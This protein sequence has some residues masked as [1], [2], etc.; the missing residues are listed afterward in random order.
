MDRSRAQNHAIDVPGVELGFRKL[1]LHVGADQ[2]MIRRGRR[3]TLNC[4][5]IKLV[6][7][8]FRDLLAV[9]GDGP[10]FRMDAIAA[11]LVNFPVHEAALHGP[12]R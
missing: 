10:A 7:M 4:W 8:N 11:P 1:S 3:W 5:H 2:G 12:G 6:I 9:E